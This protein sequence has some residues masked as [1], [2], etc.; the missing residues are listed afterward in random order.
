MA[1]TTTTL[2]TDATLVGSS[3]ADI[4]TFATGGKITVNGKEGDDRLTIATVAVDSGTLGFGSGTDTLTISV[5]TGDDGISSKMG[6]DA[7]TIVAGAAV[8]TITVGGQQGA[9][10][11]N[12]DAAST[13][14]RYAG[15]G[16]KD[17]FDVD[18]DLFNTTL[19]GGS[20][21]DEFNINTDDGGALNT[22][23]INGQK[24]KDTIAIADEFDGTIRGGSENDTI[25][26]TDGDV[27][28]NL[29]AGDAGADTITDAAGAN[30]I[31]GGGGADTIDG[32]GGLDTITGGLG[33]D[34][35]NYDA[36]DGS[37]VTITTA[38]TAAQL[39]L[40][41]STVTATGSF[42]TFTDFEAGDKFVVDQSGAAAVVGAL[43][44]IA[45]DTA[46]IIKGDFA[47]ST[48][49][50]TNYNGADALLY[51]GDALLAATADVSADGADFVLIRGG[52]A[53]TTANLT[54]A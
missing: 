38:D 54:L 40:E 4:V 27:A 47:T 15:G 41:G 50:I 9:D 37:T 30:T 51:V 44:A 11:F 14:S 48:T 1:Y 12:L 28:G 52:G 39:F 3:A 2:G 6:A 36:T 23:F 45:N 17:E 7:D 35:I 25:T 16:G 5:A 21:D 33:Q 32:A 20:G 34:V 22:G 24:G 26:A 18:H 53:M 8:D 19:I 10:F 49:F 29:I 42:E 31:E 46:Y 13:D 43:T